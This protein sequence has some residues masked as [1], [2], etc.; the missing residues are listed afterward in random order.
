MWMG[1]QLSVGQVINKRSVSK[2]TVSV[3]LFNYCITV[4]LYN[5]EECG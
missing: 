5:K 4:V 1:E 2:K 3:V